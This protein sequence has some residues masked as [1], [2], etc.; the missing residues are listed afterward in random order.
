MINLSGFSPSGLLG[1]LLRLPLHI[2]PGNFVV[3]VLQGPMRG[4]KWIVGAAT[5]GCWLG[6]Y[7]ADKQLKFT[8]ILQRGDVVLDV[9]AN[10]G[11]YTL[12]AARCVG[13]EGRVIAVEPNPRN[14]RFLQRHIALNEQSQV[15]IIA[16]A[17]GS[18]DGVAK[19]AVDEHAEMGRLAAHGTETVAVR[20]LDSLAVELGLGRVRMMKIDVEGAELHVLRGASVILERDKPFIFLATHGAQVTSDCLDF[21]SARGYRVDPLMVGG[22]SSPNEFIATALHDWDLLSGGNRAGETAGRFSPSL[23]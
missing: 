22:A 10:V 16:A 18:S 1:R 5:H 11:F 23:T 3:R 6:T 14:V 20:A 4:A 13:A 2:L 17:A 15:R 9:G 19:F 8:T 12:L 7:E 21:L